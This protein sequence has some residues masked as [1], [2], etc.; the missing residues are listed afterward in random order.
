MYKF[1]FKNNF[2]ICFSELVK[3]DL[4]MVY[5]G[6]PYVVPNGIV[7]TISENQLNSRIQNR[8]DLVKILFVSN[9]L[10]AKGVFDIIEA[11]LLIPNKNFEITMIGATSE[12]STSLKMQEKIKEFGLENCFYLVG[13]KY[14]S[15]KLEHFL[16]SDIF[17]F[18]THNEGFGNVALE[19]MEASL[20]IIAYKEGSLPYIVENETTG[21][22]VPKKNISELAKKM[23]LLI[24][25]RTLREKMG[26]EGR[27]RFLQLFTIEQFEENII[28]TLN[29][30]LLH[31]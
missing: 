3:N 16:N 31:E 19:A 1:S 11:A 15:E 17:V 9:F 14:D 21:F 5:K 10:E 18:P 30:I 8:S 29:S 7:P 12:N 24:A 25:D 22:I 23:E 28:H 20:P 26:I 6:S 27:K 2:V 13:P 4:N